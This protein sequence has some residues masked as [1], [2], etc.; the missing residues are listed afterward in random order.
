[1]FLRFSETRGETAEHA[2]E[3]GLGLGSGLVLG[4]GLGWVDPLSKL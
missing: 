3:L 4:L 2:P 1:M